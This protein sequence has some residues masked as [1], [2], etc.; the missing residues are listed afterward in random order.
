MKQLHLMTLMSVCL[1][2]L[3]ISMQ[4]EC[5][6]QKPLIFVEGNIGAGKSTFLKILGKYLPAVITLEPC[7]EWQNVGGH[8]LLQA[9]YEDI[10]RWAC[11]FQ[12]YANIT[13]IQKQEKWSHK[14][15]KIQIME[16]SWFTDRYCFA[17]SLYDTSNI[18][19]LSW[20]V[21]VRLW[22]FNFTRVQFPVG[23]IYLRVAPEVCMDRM[24][25]RARTEEVGVSFE[26][27]SRLHDYHEQLLVDKSVDSVVSDVPVLILDGSLDFKN[28]E[29]VQR[30]FVRQILDFLKINGNIDLTM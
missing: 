23:F 2:F 8:N 14:D 21:F 9:Y 28:D 30:M 11:L 15:G 16:R 10:S 20:N 29:A 4:A 17:R 26:Y 3:I 19:E 7:D 5:S 1:T 22:D 13:R 24:K 12:M 25:K 6:H 27:L 18:D